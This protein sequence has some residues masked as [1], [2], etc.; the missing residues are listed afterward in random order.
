[1]NKA[2]LSARRFLESVETLRSSCLPACLLATILIAS[3]CR[4]TFLPM[5]LTTAD[6][7]IHKWK[8]A[9]RLVGKEDFQHFYTYFTSFPPFVLFHSFC[10]SSNSYSFLLNDLF[11]PLENHFSCRLISFLSRRLC[12]V[13]C[14][15]RERSLLIPAM[16]GLEKET[17]KIWSFT[18]NFCNLAMERYSGSF[19]LTTHDFPTLSRERANASPSLCW[20]VSKYKVA[21]GI[22]RLYTFH[23]GGRFYIRLLKDAFYAWE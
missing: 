15:A 4:T 16:K 3:V 22:L 2:L 5:W 21:S 18:K 12:A 19:Q 23:P 8:S 14:R 11:G 1:M 17:R 9:S 10:T 13:W 6:R 20:C 7:G